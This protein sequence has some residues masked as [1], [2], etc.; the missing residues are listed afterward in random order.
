MA[1]KFYKNIILVRS[2]RQSNYQLCGDAIGEDL[3][4]NPDLVAQNAV[5]SFKTAMWFWTTA[6]GNKPSCEDVALNRWTPT[7]DDTAA[8]RVPGYGV[9][10]NIINGGLECG[11]GQDSRV[12][13]RIGYYTRYCGLLG[14]DPGS[15]LDCYSQRNFA[16]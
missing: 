1:A 2:I 5:V 6:Q 13:D 10:T 8:G 11:I 14:T 4:G 12:A 7:A 16:S 15:N 9:I 3:V